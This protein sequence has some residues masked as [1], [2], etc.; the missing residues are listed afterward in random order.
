MKKRIFV[1]ED[2]VLI[3]DGLCRTLDQLGYESLEP[4]LS[5]KEAIERF[6][7]EEMDLVILD[8]Y[9]GGKK[10]GIDVAEYIRSKSDTPHIFLSSY[11]DQQT[12]DLAKQ[13]QPYAYLVKPFGKEDVFTAIE[14]AFNNYERLSQKKT[15]SISQEYI[16]EITPTEKLVLQK[17]KENLTSKEIAVELN[18]SLSTVK[19][20]RHN[21]CKK[22]KL[23]NTTHSL[24]NW[25][26]RNDV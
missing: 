14:V 13:T 7:K 3:A 12:L 21:I 17:I 11:S 5:Y 18:I 15:I 16:S 2:E 4:A 26:L 20:H 1:V 19:N 22:L 6:D 25:V 9:L 10:T 23:P 8:I 24:L